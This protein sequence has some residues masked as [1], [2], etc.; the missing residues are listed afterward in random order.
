MRV[1]GGPR[2]S[3]GL[4]RAVIAYAVLCFLATAFV[5]ASA[6]VSG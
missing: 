2:F 6:L 3:P 4:P 1:L 5:I